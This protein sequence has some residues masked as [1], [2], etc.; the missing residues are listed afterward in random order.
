MAP[1]TPQHLLN[2]SWTL[3]RLSPLHHEKEFAT[4]S[5]PTALKTYASRLQDQLTGSTLGGLQASGIT[6]GAVADDEALSRTGALNSCTWETLPSLSFLE[7]QTQSRS[8]RRQP[9]QQPGILVILEYENIVYKAALLAPPPTTGSPTSDRKGSTHLPLLLTRLPGPL[10][11]TFISFLAANF[12]TYCS[13]L[14][15]PSHFMCAGLEAYVNGI[16]TEE[17]DRAAQRQTV[18]EDVVKEMQITLSFS[19]SIAP[20]L[21]SLNVNIPRGSLADFVD[22]DREDGSILSSLSSYLEKH[23]AM[24]L[25]LSAESNKKISPAKEHVR[26][27]RISCGGFLLG[28]DGRLKLV[29][30]QKM[31]PGA[32]V[33]EEDVVGGEG[34]SGEAPGEKARLMLRANEALLL[35]VL[36]RVA[37]VDEQGV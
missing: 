25:D 23:L 21:R 27:S 9:K 10:R 11:Q 26:V 37:S 3:H 14:R 16:N 2:T 34:G 18:L 24:K 29:S 1:A 31:I 12:D 13:A 36:R 7:P 20:E 33:D 28:G 30:V 5:T 19:S 35:A 4:L 15:F 32:D 22:T 8:N 6:S 17:D